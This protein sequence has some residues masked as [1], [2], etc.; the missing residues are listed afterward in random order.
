MRL[1]IKK[2]V[3]AI[4]SV[5]LLTCSYA[6][7]EDNCSAAQSDAEINSCWAKEKSSAESE[8][9]SEYA[10]AKQRIAKAYTTHKELLTQ[11]NTILL[12]SQ[13]GWLKYRDNQCKLEAFMADENTAVYASL[14]DQCTAR[15]DRERIAQLKSMPYE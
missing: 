7:A 5:L 11:Y 4:T 9:N 8:L 12:D 3:L 6:Y 13:R 10:S 14:V 1:V 2:N 15:I